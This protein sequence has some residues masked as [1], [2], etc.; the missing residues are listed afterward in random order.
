MESRKAKHLTICTNP[1][2]YSV[3]GKSPHFEG[4]H[5]VHQPL[6][7]INEAEI[8][9]SL[10]FLGSRIEL[11]MFISCMTGGS[12]G[13]FEANK[14]L[15]RAAEQLGIPV[16]LGS[17]RVL[18]D[19]PEL[20]H[21]FHIKQF[22]P[23]V[24]VLANLGSVQVRDRS[25]SQ[26]IDLIEWLEVQSLVVHLNPGQEMFQPEGDRD[27]RG[28][29]EALAGL[30]EASPVPI[31]VKETGFGIPLPLIQELIS[32]G[33]AY[34]DIAGSGGT[35]WISV[36]SYRG[37]DE[38]QQPAAEFDD[39]GLPTSLILASLARTDLR[40]SGSILASGGLRSGM[41]IVKSLVLGAEMAGMALPFIREERANGTEG[42]I[43]LVEELKST[44]RS[45]MLLTGSHDL[46]ALRQQPYW[47]DGEFSRTVESFAA[48]MGLG[49]WV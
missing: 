19:H 22:A 20:F 13:G 39:W 29:K 45:A 36:E 3:E 24:P 41:D 34:V 42:V 32:L 21:H 17:V 10:E 38:M 11:P 46:E 14:N 40:G 6:P 30:I 35:N 23:S 2:K 44:L 49:V 12:E 25:R 16:G 9:T 43:R 8:D 26:I 7:E 37:P 28:L 15:A 47:L 18:F 5:L 1:Q 48:T 31:I 33:I 4:I 27:F